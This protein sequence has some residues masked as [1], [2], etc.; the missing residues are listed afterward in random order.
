MGHLGVDKTLELLKG[1]FFWPPMRKDVQRH[2][3]R[4]ISCLK[5]KCKAMSHAL[6][7]PLPF[8]STPWEDISMDF[9]LK[10]PRTTKDFYSIFMVMD[11]F[12][13]ITHFI[14]CHKVDDANNISRLF[15]RELV[16]LQGLPKIIVLIRDPKIIGLFLKTLLETLGI[17][18]KIS[19][20]CHPQTNG[21]NGVENISLSTMPRII[22]RDN[23]KSRHKY[24]PHIEFAY[25]KVVHKTT[26]ISPFEAVYGLNPLTP[27]NLLRLPNPKEFVPKKGVT[28]V[29]FHK[30]MHARIKEKI[31]Q[32]IEKY[33][34]HSNKRKKEI[35]FEEGD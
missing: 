1:K 14:S 26:N 12:S 21:Q 33:L 4:Y 7:T 3:H 27:S 8:A 30:K 16:R 24:L 18:L 15:F 10:L 5:T 31:H 2:Y 19:I 17:K 20:P 13:K 34:K 23:H 32:E 35:N 22:M 11:R 25:N 9:I 29:Q 6:Y 28:K